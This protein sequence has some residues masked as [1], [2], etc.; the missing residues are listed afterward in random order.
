MSGIFISYRREDSAPYAGRIYDRLSAR[1]GADQVF[2]DVDDI[3]PGADFS[4]HIGAKVG[5]CDAMVVVIGKSWLTARDAKGQ[6][7]LSAPDDFVATEIALALQRNILVIPALV[8]RAEMPKAEELRGDLKPLAQR[9][10]VSLNDQDFNRDVEQIVATLEKVPGL[11]KESEKQRRDARRELRRRL[12]R[13]LLWK[14]PIVLLLVSFAIWWQWRKEEGAKVAGNEQSFGLRAAQFT[15]NWSG[16]VTYAWGDKF[17]EQ[18]FFQPEGSKLFGA[19]GFL[20]VKRGIEE[21]KIE[22]ESISFFI[23]FQESSGGMVRDHKNY[24]WGKLDGDKVQMRLQ[25]DRGNPP[26]D[27]VLSKLSS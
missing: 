26:V 7:R 18:F 9:N 4:A 15:G 3:P 8:G 23:R 1:F 2:M 20:G 22:G 19:A 27:F 13:R 10:A 25:D 12:W 6:L 14:A 21:G 16:E 24:Y 11:P 5:S 17:S